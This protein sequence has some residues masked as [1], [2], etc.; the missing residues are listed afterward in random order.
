MEEEEIC[1]I[2]RLES[3]DAID[4]FPFLDRDLLV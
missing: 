3:Y 2:S 1:F 4:S